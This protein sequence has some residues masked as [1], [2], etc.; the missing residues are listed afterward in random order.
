MT[1]DAPAHAHERVLSTLNED[2]SRR[3]LYPRLSKGRFLTRRRLVAY[4]LLIVYNALPWI[5]I[6]GKPSIH[7]NLP[8]R[9]F[10]FFGATFLPT[11]TVLL[12]LF[13][14]GLFVLIFLLTALFGRVWCG[15]AC[16]QTVYLEFIY[17][18][19]ERLFEGEPTARGERPKKI[20]GWRVAGKYVVFFLISW[21][22]AH[23][24]LAYFV[25]PTTLLQWSTQSPFDHPAA[26]TIVMAVTGLML[27]DFV[28]FREQT[29]IVACPYGRFQ[30]V[31]LDRQSLI[32]S[33]DESRGEPRGKLKKRRSKGTPAKDD[34][35]LKVV[36]EA[37]VRGDCIDCEMC[38]T[39]C[40]TGIDIR[41]GLQMECIGC[42]QCIDACDSVMDRIGRPRGLI[43]YSSQAAMEENRRS[44]IRP[45]VFIY[46]AILSIIVIAFVTVLVT[47]PAAN[48]TIHRIG[49][50]AYT[51]VDSGMA[52]G[53][54]RNDLELRIVNRTN[55]PQRY[56]FTIGG[57]EGGELISQDQNLELPAGGRGR[58]AVSLFVPREAFTMGRAT[59]TITLRDDGGY[60]REMTYRL[61]G[62]WGSESS[63]SQ[64]RET[65]P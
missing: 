45:R 5:S 43:R 51:V 47:S 44:V 28:Y 49:D 33:Y 11:D 8:A 35:S 9:E 13:V 29:C 60:E 54:V 7:L 39:T 10:T 1:T 3:W 12:M 61:Q 59:A 41:R 20:P 27:F 30:S 26:F 21:H 46:P 32:I 63:D 16:P 56:R 14:A 52:S 31:M 40:P 64:K 18:P 42:A 15:W 37:P 17:R 24:F 58:A 25:E 57:I 2:G 22:L 4:V 19:I 38:V 36:H 55:E 65:A 62:P 6:G 53:M 34:L 48:V 23:T 50:R